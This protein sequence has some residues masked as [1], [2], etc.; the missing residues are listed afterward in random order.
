MFP[1]DDFSQLLGTGSIHWSHAD[2]PSL[3]KISSSS[4]GRRN[5]A[6]CEAFGRAQ[7]YWNGCGTCA[8]AGWTD[9]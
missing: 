1:G 5:D 6:A 7:A 2:V 4:A 9:Y 8:S 3:Q